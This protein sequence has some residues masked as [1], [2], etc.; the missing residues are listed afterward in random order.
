MEWISVEDRLPNPDVKVLVFSKGEIYTDVMRYGEGVGDYWF[1]LE[2]M[3]RGAVNV[4][5]WS[6]LPEPPQD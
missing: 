1:D 2:H 3:S 6:P 4:T 5:H